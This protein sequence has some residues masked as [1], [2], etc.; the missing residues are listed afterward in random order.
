MADF[1]LVQSMPQEEHEFGDG[2]FGGTVIAAD[3]TCLEK[4]QTGFV[5]SHLDGATLALGDVDDDNATFAGFFQLADEPFFLGGIAGTESL[6][7]NGFQAGNMKHGVDNAFL[8]AGKEGEHYDIGVEKVVR[9]HGARRVGAS[10]EVLVIAD[11]DAC[12]CQW[13]IVE[14]AESVEILG[15]DF[16]GTVAPHQLVL[17]EDAHFRDDRSTVRMLGGGYFNGGDEVLFPV[18]AQGADGKLGTGEDDRLGK[19]L[20][21]ETEGG[22][23]IGH[24]VGTVQDDEAVEVVVVVVDD[25]TIFA[26]R[27]GSMSEE[28]IGGSN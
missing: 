11:M 14:G 13:G 3:D 25:F 24:G 27:E 21:H 10:D 1:G 12:L 2:T 6:E 8:D 20:E 15:I 4:L 18:G 5:T 19:V 16:G 28:S 26:Q 7:D 17:E 22:G 23:C 9:L